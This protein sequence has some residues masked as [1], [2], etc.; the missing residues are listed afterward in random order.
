MALARRN[1]FNH[2]VGAGE[3][4]GRNLEAERFRGLEVDDQPRYSAI[5]ALGWPQALT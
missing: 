1:S 3:E 4:G 2:L 5:S